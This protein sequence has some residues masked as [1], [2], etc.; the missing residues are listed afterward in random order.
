MLLTNWQRRKAA[1]SRIW[2]TVNEGVAPAQVYVELLSKHVLDASLDGPQNQI[3]SKPAIEAEVVES[4][5][6]HE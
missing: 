3:E 2:G 6:T 4:E 5:A 1:S